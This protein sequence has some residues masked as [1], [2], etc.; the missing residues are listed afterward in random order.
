MSEIKHVVME[1]HESEYRD[2]TLL[3]VF[4]IF[5]FMI[6]MQGSTSMTSIWNAPLKK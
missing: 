4:G 1:K 5:G 2:E 3:A 6:L